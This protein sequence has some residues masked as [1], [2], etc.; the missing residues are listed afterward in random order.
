[1]VLA[2]DI[3]TSAVKAGIFDLEGR[4]LD[5]RIMPVTLLHGNGEERYEIDPGSWLSALKGALPELLMGRAD[6]ISVV[7]VSGNG[8]TLLCID[9]AG[10][11]LYP[12]ITWMDRRGIDEAGQAAVESALEVD[13][14]FYLAKAYWIFK[15]K[16]ELYEKTRFFIPCPDYINYYLT[17]NA[18]AVLPS[19][20]F[21]RLMWTDRAVTAL[22]MDPNRFPPFVRPGVSLGSV[23]KAAAAGTGLNAGTAVAAGGPDFLMSLLGTGTL[24]PGDTCD[25][26]GTSEGINHCTNKECS[27]MRLICLPHLTEGLFNISGLISTTGKA[28]EW[29]ARIAGYHKEGFP[30]LYRDIRDVPPGARRLL[31][32]PY[33]AGRRSV[34]RDPDAKGCFVGLT[35]LHGRKEMARAVAESI[36]FSIQAILEIMEENAFHVSDIRVAGSQA[37]NP[38]LNQIKADI[39]GRNIL[40]PAVTESELMGGACIGLASIGAFASPVEASGNCVRIRSGIQPDR[41]NRSL[42]EDMFG[43][44]KELYIELKESFKRLSRLKVEK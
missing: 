38:V 16:P 5:R 12:A 3:G 18:C 11:V 44:F 21:K 39:T 42:Y 22:G 7:V 31:F 1:M 41:G 13:A 37:A 32:L 28:L 35:L 29:Y 30:T 26:A 14:S 27:D 36:G 15:E 9:E 17:G 6:E 25:R 40:I 33:L 8:P 24:A 34:H 19:S 4:L 2:L 43:L 20:S 10:N 23:G